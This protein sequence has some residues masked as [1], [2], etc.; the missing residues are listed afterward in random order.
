MVSSA[1][2]RML[3]VAPQATLF[4][5]LVNAQAQLTLGMP[6]CV[7]LRGVQLFGEV[8]GVTVAG[9]DAS[10]AIVLRVGGPQ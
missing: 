1:A 8:F 5:V 3:L 10:N 4:G 7:Q 6:Q 2:G 9:I